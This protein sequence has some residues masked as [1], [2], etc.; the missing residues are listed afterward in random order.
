MRTLIGLLTYQH[1]ISECLFI[2]RR[3]QYR[4]HPVIRPMFLVVVC[5]G[6]KFTLY[7]RLAIKYILNAK[8]S[9]AMVPC[10]SRNKLSARNKC[11]DPAHEIHVYKMEVTNKQM[12]KVSVQLHVKQD[13]LLDHPRRARTHRHAFFA[14]VALILTR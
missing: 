11:F 14:P 1:P 10:T 2:A 9:G 7:A 5:N 4:S 6:I 3:S 12:C 8:R 13:C